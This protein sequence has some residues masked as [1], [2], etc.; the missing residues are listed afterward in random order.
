MEILL[1]LWEFHEGKQRLQTADFALRFERVTLDQ[2]FVFALL[3]I[4]GRIPGV[5]GLSKI[6]KI[7]IFELRARS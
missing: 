2:G 7:V 4:L 5:N 1:S 6:G 3:V